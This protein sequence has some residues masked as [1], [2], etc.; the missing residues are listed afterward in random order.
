MIVVA[1]LF[2][3]GLGLSS[4]YVASG[5]QFLPFSEPFL[6]RKLQV[7]NDVESNPGPKNATGS[8]RKKSVIGGNAKNKD[9]NMNLDNRESLP[10]N[11]VPRVKKLGK[12][13][14]VF[15]P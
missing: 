2:P 4:L 10:A 8:P 7:C 6:A 1:V 9:T 14:K 11:D 3:V 15:H 5:L 12:S 13:W